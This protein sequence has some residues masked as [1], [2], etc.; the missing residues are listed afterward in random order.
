MHRMEPPLI[1]LAPK[2]IRSNHASHGAFSDSLTFRYLRQR[3]AF[4]AQ[5]GAPRYPAPLLSLTGRAAVSTCLSREAVESAAKP[6]LAKPSPIGPS[7]LRVG[8][9]VR[10]GFCQRRPS[11][12]RLTS[13]PGTPMAEYFSTTP[14]LAATCVEARHVASWTHEAEVPRVRISAGTRKLLC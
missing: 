3:G 5:V 7:P 10:E 8:F 2:S 6:G 4:H 11:E 13:K 12:L 9:K 1:S 14:E